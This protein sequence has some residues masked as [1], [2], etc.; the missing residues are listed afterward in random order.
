MRKFVAVGAVALAW[1]L[2]C[3]IPAFAT[4]GGVTG[5]AKSITTGS[6]LSRVKI[7]KGSTSVKT[8]SKGAYTLALKAGTYT[9]SASKTGRL[10]TYQVVKV[11]K[12][13]KTKVNWSLTKSYPS[14]AV[15]S[16]GVTILGWNDLGMHCDQDSYEYFCILPP[17]NTIHV[18]LFSGEGGS[19]S[20][21]DVTYAFAKKTDSTLHTDFWT[22]ASN[23]GWNVAP[24]VGITG[25]SLTGTMTAGSH[26][27]TA[28]GIPVTPYDDDGTWDPYAPATIT[29]KNRTNG[30]VL[31][32]ADVVVPVSS[33]LSCPSCHT[34]TL[35]PKNAYIDILSVHDANETTT[36]LADAQAGHPHACFECHPDAAVNEP[37][38]AGTSSLSEAIHKYHA[39]KDAITNDTAGC[40]KCHPGPTT[41][42]LRG[43][44]AKAGK[45][46]VDCHGSMT[47]VWT[48]IANSGRRP[49]LD[50]PKC[51]TCHGSSHA[52][53]TGTLYRNSLLKNAVR[54]DMNNRIYCEA[55]HNSTHGEYVSTSTSDA[56]VPKKFQGNSYWIYNCRVC[57][58]S[59]D[60]E[61][62]FTGQAMHR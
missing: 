50:E 8:N 42:C 49:W 38:T 4:T 1:C 62:K 30:S 12:G 52:E 25:N 54:G 31:A 47:K 7:A 36:L 43:V 2:A 21:V 26:Q 9:L 41:R 19:P 29:V 37:G 34:H 57:H 17:Y 35:D 27:Y 45:G 5:V 48:S 32:T 53:N 13:K 59:S 24:N 58:K 39:N 28:T 11:V 23:F 56:V 46:C 61:F 14:N 60:G 18:Q 16:N 22:Y 20:N 6:T 44:M 3:A 15:P 55:C 51:G 10:K 33:E 40:Y